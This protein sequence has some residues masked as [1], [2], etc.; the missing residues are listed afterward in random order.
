MNGHHFNDFGDYLLEAMSW[1]VVIAL[2]A[3]S[4]V[5]SFGAP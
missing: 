2:F 5:L 1:L 4:A 3:A